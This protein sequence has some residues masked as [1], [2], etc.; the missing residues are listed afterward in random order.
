MK[1]S[2]CG[3]ENLVKTSNVPFGVNGDARMYV[4]K[5]EVFIC[6]DCAHVEFFNHHFVEEYKQKYLKYNEI[7]NKIKQIESQIFELE[8]KPFDEN[9]YKKELKIY[10][11]ERDTMIRLN[12]DNKSIRAKE[13][14]IK[15]V[16]NILDSKVDPKVQ[17]SIQVLNNEKRT[18]EEELSHIHL[19][20]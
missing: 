15:D 20:N 6:L 19:D 1:C 16:Q 7:K 12:V 11:D 14:C 4:N 5:E 10:Q 9:K 3:G 13:E 2:C 17:R 8:N 18:L